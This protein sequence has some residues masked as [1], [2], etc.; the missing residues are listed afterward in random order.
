MSSNISISPWAIHISAN[1]PQ[2]RRVGNG[3][4]C[5]SGQKVCGMYSTWYPIWVRDRIQ[6][7]CS[8]PNRNSSFNHAEIIQQH[9]EREV[10]L[11]RM[12]KCLYGSKPSCVHTSPIGIIPKKNKANK[13]RLIIDLS[14]P[15]GLSVNDGISAELSSLCYTSV[16]HL[17]SIIL[18]VGKRGSASE[19]RYKRGLQDGTS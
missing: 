8:A 16:D 1:L 18:S 9:L 2:T 15:K 11:G 13:W 19:S 5:T 4:V 7:F 12:Y 14:S 17:S 6:Q 10:E 3:A